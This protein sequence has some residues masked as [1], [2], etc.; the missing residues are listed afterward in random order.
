MSIVLLVES[1]NCWLSLSESQF[2]A[3]RKIIIFI[4]VFFCVKMLKKFDSHDI[5]TRLDMI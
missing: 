3:A 5:I 2:E 4:C 1:C